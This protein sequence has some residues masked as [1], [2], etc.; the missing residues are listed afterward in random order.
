M[1]TLTPTSHIFRKTLRH[2]SHL[3]ACSTTIFMGDWGDIGLELVAQSILSSNSAKL[4]DENAD[5]ERS[6]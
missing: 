2:H 3:L 1:I 4:Y 6:F 5:T